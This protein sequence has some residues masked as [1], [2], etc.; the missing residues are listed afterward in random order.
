MPKTELT[1]DSDALLCA[2]YKDY[3]QKR[4]NGESKDTAKNLGSASDIQSKIVPKW[5]LGDV[6][7]TLRTLSSS[8]M[9]SCFYADD[10]VHFAELSEKGIFYMENRFKNGISDVLD[11]LQKI[12]SILLW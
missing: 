1:K 8:E 2:I 5:I 6:E 10:T 7:E 4:K 12:K 3:L 9:V 11:H